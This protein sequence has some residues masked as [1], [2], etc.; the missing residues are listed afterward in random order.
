MPSVLAQS[1]LPSL[2]MDANSNSMRP[3]CDWCCCLL[4]V[5]QAAPDAHVLAN[6]RPVSLRAVTCG[7]AV[8]AAAVMCC[9]YTPWVVDNSWRSQPILCHPFGMDLGFAFTA[10]S[11]HTIGGFCIN[12]GA[13]TQRPNFFNAAEL[14]VQAVLCR[15]SAGPS[16][17]TQRTARHGRMPDCAMTALPTLQVV[18]VACP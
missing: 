9:G 16:C 17:T 10:L 11:H 14:P 5:R 13:N 2:L 15:V 12:E 8:A 18:M 6:L 1:S 4:P 3:L 7:H